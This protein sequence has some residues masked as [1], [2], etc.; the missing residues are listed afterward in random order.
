M[1][2]ASVRADAWNRSRRT[3]A[4]RDVLGRGHGGACQS[5]SV[6][7]GLSLRDKLLGTST[8]STLSLNNNQKRSRYNVATL[9]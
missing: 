1:S 6:A 3:Q 7:G 4:T 2:E 9:G 8:F 5:F